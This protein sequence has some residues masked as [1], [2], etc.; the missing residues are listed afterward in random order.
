MASKK[1]FVTD[2]MTVSEILNMSPETLSKLNK[3]EI[4][5]ALRTV[6]LAANKRIARLKS[7]A[8]KTSEGYV[9][10]GKKSGATIATD[11]LNW[12]TN[13]GHSRTKFGVKKSETRNQ[14]I[15]QLQ[16]AKKFMS[17][18][19]STVG[20]ATKLRKAR[21]KK[22]FGKTREQAARSQTTKKGK[23]SVYQMFEQKY[24]DVWSAYRKFL[25]I[26]GR[27]P[28]S[29]LAGSDSILEL[30]GNKVLTGGNEEDAITAALEKFTSE[31]E[32]QQQEYNELFN[33]DDFWE[34]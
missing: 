4:S 12:V 18:Q 15:A 20:G 13:D 7:H 32:A 23:Q 22:L 8:T 24:K 2:G 21:E 29:Y 33:D 19:S 27:D 5:R 16:K 30:I 10:S 28:H 17:M 9:S 6:S 3:R 11:A 1:G 25:E 31:Y 14:M 34:I 26:K